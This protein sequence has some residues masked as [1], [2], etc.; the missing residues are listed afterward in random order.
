MGALHSEEWYLGSGAGVGDSF[1]HHAIR[2][3]S[4]KAMSV[5][6]EIGLIGLNIAGWIAVVSKIASPEG[7]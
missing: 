1:V 5:D 6:G 2:K 3:G 7:F 4:V